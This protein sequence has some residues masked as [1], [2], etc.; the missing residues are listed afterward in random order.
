[1]MDKSYRNQFGYV[2]EFAYNLGMLSG[3]IQLEAA[4]KVTF[5]TEQ[6]G[7]LKSWF[8]HKN[9]HLH[10]LITSFWKKN[11]MTDRTAQQL[12]E[13]NIQQIF[14]VAFFVGQQ[15]IKDY[16]SSLP[17][18]GVKKELLY[19]QFNAHDPL[20]RKQYQQEARQTIYKSV[21][22]AFNYQM[23]PGEFT[24]YRQ[25]GHF[26]KAD[27]LLLFRSRGQLY[28]LVTDNGLY[29]HH[30]VGVETPY[31]LLQTL[32]RIRGE[33]GSKTKFHHLSM[34]AKALEGMHLQKL[35]LKYAEQ[36]R[37]K[38][39]LKVVQ[40]GSYAYSF[41]KFLSK[42]KKYQACHFSIMGQVDVDF[43][44]FN[45]SLP[46]QGWEESEYG[47]LLMECHKSYCK[48]TEWDNLDRK[49]IPNH[50]KRL[51]RLN[52]LQNT[53]IARH[54]LEKLMNQVEGSYTITDR[55]DHFQSTA[56]LYTENKTFRHAHAEAVR[57]GLVNPE[58]PI[59]FLT[60]CPGIGKTT[61][62]RDELKRRDRYLFLYT[63][64][65]RAVNDDI[66]KKFS[67]KRQL[68]T[69]DLIVLNTTSNDEEMINGKT[70]FVVNT[71]I[72]DEKR[73][74]QEG[75]IQYLPIGRERV[76]AEQST[77]FRQIGNNK[78][79][80]MSK[81]YPGV[82][83][84]LFTGIRDQLERAEQKKI[85]GTFAIQGFKQKINQQ[86]TMEYFRRMFPFII[87]RPETG[88]KVDSSKFDHFVEQ[89]PTCWIMID[90]I[91]GADEGVRIY[92]W[93]KKFLFGEVIPQLSEEQ[94]KKWD[95]KLIV[96]DAS[97]TDEQVAKQYLENPEQFDYPKV[98]ITRHQEKSHALTTKEISVCI[99]KEEVPTW[100]V[101]ANSYPA[102]SLKMAYHIGVE[103]I[104]LDA[105]ETKKATRER[106]SRE[107]R[108]KKEQ[109][110]QILQ[111]IFDHFEQTQGTEQILVYVQDI[112]RIEQLKQAYIQ[113]YRHLFGRVPN[114]GQDFLTITSQLTDKERQQ[115]LEVNEEVHCVFMTSSAARG[116]SFPRATHLLAVLQT[117]HLERELA[118]QI[119]VYYRMRGDDNL[120]LNRIK[121]IDFF[122]ADSYVYASHEKEEKRSRTLIH[123][124]SFLTLVRSCF[125]TRIAG[126]SSFGRQSLSL[127]PLGG[128]GVTSVQQS[129]I[130]VASD[131]Q[132]LLKKELTRKGLFQE[133]KQLEKYLKKLFHHLH[134]CFKAEIYRSN[135]L[136]EQVYSRFQKLAKHR[137][138]KL[139]NFQPF[140]KY[141]YINGLLVFRLRRSSEQVIP[142]YRSM[143]AD[144][145]KLKK[146]VGKMKNRQ[147]LSDEMRKKMS[148]IY[149]LLSY[150]EKQQA[151]MG[152]VFSEVLFGSRRYFAIPLMAFPFEQELQ[153]KGV[154]QNDQENFL[155]ALKGLI[156]AYTDVSA[157]IPLNYHYERIPY[158][159]FHSE[160]LSEQY[161][162]RFKQNR[163]FV[164]TETNIVN[165]LLLQNG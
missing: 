27:S 74:P 154:E 137:F 43:S 145:F 78:I 138:S 99:N 94:C 52:L 17:G 126:E 38:T 77:R 120:D 20:D 97:I 135:D 22:E 68:Y 47:Q 21:M 71:M 70:A 11:A 110:K 57:E 54:S 42:L 48:N 44:V 108:V 30:M 142:I 113:R 139:L 132:R 15:T 45:A 39:L 103:G 83:Q 92:Q 37:D 69:D 124:L 133:Q 18:V 24:A 73:L 65:R 32:L 14:F 161:T 31:Q 75:P 84:R 16:V 79:R 95:L 159:L 85:I 125:V 63:S 104:C 131:L 1:M 123:L 147:T 165:L 59:L 129:L 162:N 62:I 109:N 111:K 101:N 136:A 164:S 115:A 66:I 122:L 148:Q 117:F 98:Y 141:M 25:R 150:E 112:E 61:A 58:T 114:E 9:H 119:Q 72:N 106:Q 51:F 88:V 56:S 35:L 118:E 19:F 5:H 46:A 149:D 26:L 146:W 33:L 90:E 153:K 49:Q 81:H 158:I 10:S 4:K 34:E 130:H 64:C 13:R 96:A 87:D 6:I 93:L 28:L 82:Y 8:D 91:S 107:Y 12:V 156:Q 151:Q 100:L 128:K 157:V 152:N 121:T 144:A 36:V 160:S 155:D 7:V 116:I 163:L 80:Q 89:Y 105:W 55:I 41:L 134:V 50:V 102:K 2:Y 140:Q 40:A 76:Y 29:L 86:H 60:G 53:N 67:N 23:R 127:V 143:R 3:L